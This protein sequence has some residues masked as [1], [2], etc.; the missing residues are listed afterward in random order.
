MSKI[1]L[2]IGDIICRSTAYTTDTDFAIKKFI[3]KETWRNKNGT[4]CVLTTQK[5]WYVNGVEYA[6]CYIELPPLSD[7]NTSP[8]NVNSPNHYTQGGIETIDYI[9]A[10]LG[11]KG[12]VD[13]CMGNVL[14]YSS[15]Y[16][17]KNG[18]EDLQKAQVYLGWAIENYEQ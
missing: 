14:K 13:Y 8:D 6:S 2:K 1:T 11:K 12:F 3:G 16:Q 17:H 10:K 5:S 18:L 9:K 7:E 15:R 4:E